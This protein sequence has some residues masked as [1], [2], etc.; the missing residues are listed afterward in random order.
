MLCNIALD[1][2]TESQ[3]KQL[4]KMLESS[5]HEAAIHAM[6]YAAGLLDGN[7]AARR[8]FLRVRPWPKN[9]QMSDTNLSFVLTPGQPFDDSVLKLAKELKVSAPITCIALIWALFIWF[10]NGDGRVELFVAAMRELIRSEKSDDDAE[11][12]SS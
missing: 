5:F 11:V 2:E 12:R 3:I 8:D 1:V 9:A 6:N 4:A 10:A 7:E